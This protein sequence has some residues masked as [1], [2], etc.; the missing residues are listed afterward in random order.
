MNKIVELQPTR[1]SESL[2]CNQLGVNESTMRGIIKM[3]TD[4]PGEW[5]TNVAEAVLGN[6]PCRLGIKPFSCGHV[7]LL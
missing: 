6:T 2:I 5:C 1:K 7:P 4:G 3:M